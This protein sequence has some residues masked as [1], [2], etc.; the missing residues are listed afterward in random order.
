MGIL[1]NDFEEEE[2]NFINEVSTRSAEADNGPYFKQTAIIK[3]KMFGDN[4]NFG[5]QE[6][7]DRFK[8]VVNNQLKKELEE[9]NK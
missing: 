6:D 1:S 3:Q 7:F 9:K 8:T 4:L 5:S 2:R